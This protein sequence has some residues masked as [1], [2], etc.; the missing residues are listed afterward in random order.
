MKDDK[1]KKPKRDKSPGSRSRH[2]I[3]ISVI[4]SLYVAYEFGFRGT[5]HHVIVL[6]NY[7][8]KLL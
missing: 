2:C 8:C 4:F 5:M 7:F 1:K 3:I 6:K